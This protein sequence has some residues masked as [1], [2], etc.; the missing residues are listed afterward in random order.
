M[1]EKWVSTIRKSM[2]GDH[3]KVDATCSFDVTAFN[4]QRAVISHKIEILEKSLDVRGIELRSS[5]PFR[6]DCSV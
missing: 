1:T 4:H 3:F 6:S 5:I 2:D